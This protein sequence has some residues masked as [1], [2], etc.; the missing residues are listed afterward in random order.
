MSKKIKL[1]LIFIIFQIIFLVSLD[2]NLFPNFLNNTFFNESFI[3][4]YNTINN[5]IVLIK[6]PSSK[7]K[8]V[9]N[10][11]LFIPSSLMPS[12]VLKVTKNNLEKVE[13]FA[14]LHNNKS[15]SYSMINCGTIINKKSYINATKHW[16]IK[17]NWNTSNNITKNVTL[18]NTTTLPAD[19]CNK[20]RNKTIIYKNYKGVLNDK[21]FNISESYKN[22]LVYIFIFDNQKKTDEILF[23]C[24]IYKPIYY[25]PNITLTKVVPSKIV[26][27]ISIVKKDYENKTYFPIL[28][29]NFERPYFF[30]NEKLHVAELRYTINGDYNV[31]SLKK[32]INNNFTIY[33]Y[34]IFQFT[35]YCDDC[36]GKNNISSIKNYFFGPK[37]DNIIIKSKNIT[38]YND[39]KLN[40][41]GNCSINTYTFAYLEK[42]SFN[43]KIIYF[44]NISQS[45]TQT[46]NEFLLDSSQLYLNNSYPNGTLKCYYK[47]PT[48][49][50]LEIYKFSLETKNLSRN[51][52]STEINKNKTNTSKL[53]KRKQKTIP[54][55][56][57]LTI[58]LIIF[59]ILFIGIYMYNKKSFITKYIDH[60]KM[61]K[62][63][64]NIHKWWNNYKTFS[65]DNYKSDILEDE[66]YDNIIKSSKIVKFNI[67]GESVQLPYKHILEENVEVSRHNLFD[68][69]KVKKITNPSLQREYII[70]YYPSNDS[71]NEFWEMIY[72]ESI[73]II[74]SVNYKNKN[75][76]EKDSLSYWPN[77]TSI[78]GSI[79]VKL[80]KKKLIK[81]TKISIL[82]FSITKFNNIT[83]SLVILDIF[84]WMEYSILECDIDI[85]EVYKGIMK[86][87]DASKI[88]LH[89]Q[90][91]PCSRVLT[92]LYFFVILESMENDKTITDPL[93][94]ISDLMKSYN[95][96][97]INIFS[98]NIITNALI[99]YFFD[100]NI[101]FDEKGYTTYKCNYEEYINNLKMKEKSMSNNIRPFLCFTNYLNL[102]ILDYILQQLQNICIYDKNILKKMC[103]NFYA[104]KKNPELCRKI[105]YENIPC[106]DNGSINFKNFNN[107]STNSYIHGNI[108]HY[109]TYNFYKRTIILCQIPN[110]N[111]IID[112]INMIINYKVS[113]IV[114]LVNNKE[115]ITNNLTNYF[116]SGINITHQY[117]PYKIKKLSDNTDSTSDICISNYSIQEIDKKIHFV[118][119]IHLQCW[120][121]HEVPKDHK[122][123]Y[124]LY[125]LILKN[126]D[127]NPIIFQCCGGIGKSGTLALI[128]YIIDNI[129]QFTS[130][131]LLFY[132]KFIREQRHLSIL[133]MDQ[134]MLALAIVYENFKNKIDAFN[135]ILYEKF[136]NLRNTILKMDT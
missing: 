90:L 3:L 122:K 85:Y 75:N 119:C 19:E 43:T 55:F 89:S 135:P 44:K 100:K 15:E 105:N 16:L 125:K 103:S 33:G 107:Y 4:N 131:D 86:I 83:K 101:L 88:L 102:G 11:S 82:Q 27:N 127:E 79:E 21:P 94:I 50:I 34:G 30:I 42:A 106:L 13:W 57:H 136:F 84:G 63:H 78:Y 114:I 64:S 77:G 97:P 24:Q 61:K 115:I 72:N 39:R 51:N 112:T 76:N 47:T 113:T 81:S 134:F 48:Y 22:Q 71:Q 28:T 56:P 6:C 58:F 68:K 66:Y 41:Q 133:G 128:F 104:I 91:A 92:F 37:E 14:I 54:F 93:S 95:I 110:K 96:G 40:F 118:T 123:I 87:D 32:L 121:N 74:I 45:L 36:I 25:C 2:I 59:T 49:N 60:L 1:T 126:I 73:N 12:N 18:F 38:T 8:Y 116:P 108:L 98:Y 17:I 9:N 99:R 31:I 69:F 129:N 62:R 67:G 80:F 117:G 35:Y 10:E 53:K 65:I 7:F 5:D 111:T 52:I 109:Y 130:F 120:S 124:N 70:S 132:L 23:P 46:T 29:S 26:N 20:S